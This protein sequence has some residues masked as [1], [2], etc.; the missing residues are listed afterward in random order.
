MLLSDF[1]E[2]VHSAL[3]L[4]YL[5]VDVA[6]LLDVE[7]PEGSESLLDFVQ[8]DFPG[9]QRVDLERADEVLE[10][11]EGN[12]KELPLSHELREAFEHFLVDLL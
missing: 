12:I 10:L 1:V 7:F 11:R 3:H 4:L 9:W 8:V 6:L 5:H 2:S